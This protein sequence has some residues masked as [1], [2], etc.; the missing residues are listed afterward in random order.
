MMLTQTPSQTVGPFFHDALVHAED[1][2]LTKA[3]THGTHIV[4]TG[5]VLDGDGDPV[6]DALVEI[7]QADA[8]GIYRHPADPRHADAD[9]HFVGY[10]RS[11]T[12]DGGRFTFHT[13]KPGAMGPAS[14]PHINVHI[15]AR[16]M[17][18][19]AHT[20]I[21]FSDEATNAHDAVLQALPAARRATLLAQWANGA[22]CFDIVL[23]GEHETV[24]FAP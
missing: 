23:Q 13:I 9:P 4:L 19:H 8:N 22:Y 10:G 12:T 14:A 17:L 18:V 15:F 1:R 24:F 5:R 16:G 2:T 3:Q 6:S 21:Y 20:R 11:D 7:W